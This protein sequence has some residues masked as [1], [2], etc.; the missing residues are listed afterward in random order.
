MHRVMHLVFDFVAERVEQLLEVRRHHVDTSLHLGKTVADVIHQQL[1]Q[2]P[3]Q[4]KTHNHI[5]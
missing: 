5:V 1:R 4:Q 3:Q 2:K